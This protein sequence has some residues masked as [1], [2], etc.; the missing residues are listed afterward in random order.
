MTETTLE[1][2][3]RKFIESATIT[4]NNKYDYSQVEYKNASTKVII[5]CPTHGQFMQRPN[6]HRRKDGCPSCK[7]DKIISAKRKTVEQ[8]I[9]EANQC[10]FGFYDYSKSV[11]QNAFKKVEIVCPTHGSFFQ[12]PGIHIN[13]RGCPICAHNCSRG[14]RLVSQYLKLKNIEF[15]FNKT[16]PDLLNPDTNRRYRFDFWLSDYNTIIEYD[17]QQHSIPANIKGRIGNIQKQQDNYEKIVKSDKIK[18]QYAKRKGYTLIRIDYRFNTLPL[19]TQE[20]DHRL[21]LVL[22]P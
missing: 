6:D 1:R 5:I 15:K 12:S 16:F 18:S 7:F 3:R 11:Y 17:G 9:E 4:H 10:H 13:G 22:V 2:R 20:L 21:A 14:E 19:I 8:F